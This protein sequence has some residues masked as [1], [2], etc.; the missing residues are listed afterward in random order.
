MST[1]TALMTVMVAFIEHRVTH[2]GHTHL[3]QVFQYRIPIQ[4]GLVA[5]ITMLLVK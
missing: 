1:Y 3:G 2:E 5:A 4:I